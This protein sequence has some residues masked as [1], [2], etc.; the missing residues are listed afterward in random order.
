[1]LSPASSKTRRHQQETFA[2]PI[3]MALNQTQGLRRRAEYAESD[4]RAAEQ[5][6]KQ[7]DRKCKA[8]QKELATAVTA[9]AAAAAAAAAF[10]VQ[11][12]AAAADAA[13]AAA[14]RVQALEGNL[15]QAQAQAA[16]A[17]AAVDTLRSDVAVLKRKLSLE[18]AIA[19]ES[20]RRCAQYVENCNCLKEQLGDMACQLAAAQRAAEEGD[21]DDDDEDDP[22]AAAV[23]AAALAPN[24]NRKR[25]GVLSS[26]DDST[27][28]T[29]GT[30]GARSGAGRIAEPRAAKKKK[31]CRSDKGPAHR[32][33]RHTDSESPDSETPCSED[34]DYVPRVLRGRAR[35][36]PVPAFVIATPVFE[37]VEGEVVVV[38]DSD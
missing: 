2:T 19:A 28:T 27:A 5:Y 9:A 31:P 8:V 24:S 25:R 23:V 22:V 20:E 37:A 18:E 6:S 21:D 1:M 10:A 7:L 35:A 26:L 11:K 36:P 15:A 14:A 4:K 29:A 30:G 12:D 33:W 32:I 34:S 16:A 38:S 13:A 3:V 17:L